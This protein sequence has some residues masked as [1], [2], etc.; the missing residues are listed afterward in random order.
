MKR[1]IAGLLV[2]A[3][4]IAASACSPTQEGAA[5]GAGSG[6]LVGMAVS[7]GSVGGTLAGAALGTA[8]GALIG[9]AVGSN[10]QCYYRD[11]YGRQY[12]DACPPGYHR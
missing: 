1:V 4:A 5:I 9:N 6:A 7:D 3:A 2:G 12:K 10:N 11:R 8:A